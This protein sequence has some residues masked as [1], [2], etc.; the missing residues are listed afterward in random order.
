MSRRFE[1]RDRI[2]RMDA[3]EHEEIARLLS[4]YEFPWDVTQALS[5]A[6]FRTFAVPSIGRLLHD[7]GEFTKRTQKR[8]DDTVLVLDAILEN[9]LGTDDGRAAVRRMNQM[10]RS[11]DISNDDMRYVL[12]TFVVTPKRWIDEFGWRRLTP[13]EVDSQVSYYRELARHM[14]IKDVPETYA[15][16]ERLLDDYE[17][18][19]FA[20]DE[21]ARAVADATVELFLT[22]PPNNRVPRFLMMP[23]MRALMGPDLCRAFHYPVLPGP[24]AKALRRL[25]WLRGRIVRF[26]PPRRKPFYARQLNYLRTYPGGYR[27]EDLGTFPAGCPVRSVD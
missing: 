10:H 13:H 16:F 5:F 14:G 21:G 8:H 24:V 23:M 26:F 20:Y 6:L 3:S 2:Q 15:E 9:G 12:A 19:H 22:F 25:V 18:E 27:V 17:A 1:I 7:T 11:Y 4:T